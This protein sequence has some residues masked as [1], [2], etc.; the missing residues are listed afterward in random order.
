M[1]KNREQGSAV[2][3]IILLLGISVITLIWVLRPQP[4]IRKQVAPLPPLLQ[5]ISAQPEDYRATIRTQGV[6]VPRRQINLVAEV[7]GRVTEVSDTFVEGGAFES[8]QSLLKLDERDYR[9][10]FISAEA[11]VARAER[12]LALERGQAR[13]AKRVWRD[14]GSKEANALSL[15]K[16]QVKAAESSLAAAKAARDNARLN[17][18]RTHIKA[19]FSGRVETKN[20]DV[21]QFVAVGT[22]MG[23][24]YDSAAAEV[25]LPLSGDQL[26][27]ASF[28]PGVILDQANLPAVTLLADIG[29]ERQQWSAKLTRMDASVDSATRFYHV[30]AEVEQPFDVAIHKQPLLMGLFVQAEIEGKA[31]SNVIRLPKKA[32]VDNARIFVV[33]SGD[34]LAT[35]SINIIHQENDEVWVQSEITNGE[36]IV[37]SDPRV[38]R[39]DMKVRLVKHSVEEES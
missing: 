15:R 22:V 14:L 18:Q 30:V 37:V 2:T 5:I 19:P 3:V 23:T 8:R 39:E 36:A 29:G 1:F 13:Q 25:R 7:S 10:A 16:P 27:L 31:F 9:Y 11:D 4:V 17:V 38:L 26:S 24:L 12:G 32:V 20:I 35:R 34:I 33:E 21:G 28:S 6:V